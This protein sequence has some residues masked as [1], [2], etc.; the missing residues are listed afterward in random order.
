MS[1]FLSKMGKINALKNG[2]GL[3]H[4]L[5]EG[6]TVLGN[7]M[8]LFD[9]HYNL[10]AYTENAV[11]DDPFWNEL[12]SNKCF[13]K[14]TTEFFR[15]EGF[16][17]AVANNGVVAFLH[18][19]KLKYDRFNGTIFDKNYTRIANI[20]VTA[21]ENPPQAGDME[22]I[23][24]LCKVLLKEIQ[25]SDYYHNLDIAYQETLLNMLISGEEI[26]KRSEALIMLADIYK[27][28]STYIYLGVVDVS[29]YE[30]GLNNLAYFRDLCKRT[31]PAYKYFIH[32]DYLLVLMSFDEDTL[33]IK[34]D[35]A[36]LRR[37]FERND[38]YMG[39][40]DCFENLFE[41]RTHYTKA[42]E[43]LALALENGATQ[44]IFLYRASGAPEE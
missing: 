34:K 36:K 13:S 23:E 37:L 22:L 40:S 2:R 16:V 15:E 3:Q 11:T 5:D 28:L 20:N 43:A 9:I 8:L 6:H 25:T 32:A 38:L 7:P 14:Q 29:R 41:L 18:S 33:T 39:I 31:Q 30:C 10:I 12:V 26:D 35:L 21:C 44:R 1:D 27:D 4:L 19:D 17:E 24:Q 42:L